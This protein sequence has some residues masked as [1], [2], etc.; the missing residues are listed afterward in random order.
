MTWVPVK[1]YAEDDLKVDLEKEPAFFDKWNPAHS[2]ISIFDHRVAEEVQAAIF[3]IG[4]YRRLGRS[5]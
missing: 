2:Q 1:K 3:D 4:S 5:A